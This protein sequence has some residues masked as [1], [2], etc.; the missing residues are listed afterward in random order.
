[1][2]PEIVRTRTT[3]YQVTQAAVDFLT[4][5]EVYRR[6]RGNARYKG[7]SCFNC[8]KDFEDEEKLGLIITSKGNKVVCRECGLKFKRELEEVTPDATD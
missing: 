3:R 5:N 6:I 4:F 7:F 8:G 2:R 1:M